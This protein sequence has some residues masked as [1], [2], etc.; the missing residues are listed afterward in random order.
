MKSPNLDLKQGISYLER[1]GGRR[2][3]ERGRKKERKTETEKVK[4]KEREGERANNKN[5]GP[6]R[7]AQLVVYI[8]SAY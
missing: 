8:F 4:H 7:V 2:G 6:R 1:E 5:H 3:G